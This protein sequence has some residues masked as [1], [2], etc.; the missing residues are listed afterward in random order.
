[1]GAAAEA[2]RIATA[3][4]DLAALEA[5]V[6]AFE[7]CAL[8]ATA[9]NT[10]F[11]DGTKETFAGTL[12]NFN[13]TS[14][15]GTPRWHGNF[16]NT[17]DFSKYSVTASLNYFGGYDLSAEDQTGP[18]TAGQCG[19]SSGFTPCG[20]SAYTTIDLVGSMQINDKI[21]VYANI[22]NLADKMP[23]IDPVT[24]GANNYNPV[25]GGEGIVGRN[26]RLGVTYKI[27]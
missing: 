7:G 1:M 14:G 6:R 25:Q 23:P 26:F 20:V 11:A 24:Y 8:K 12:G 22:L 10:V 19:L 2:E 13:L 27:F 18:G 15:S 17:F 4:Q 9:M 5:A 21:K 16:E 3:C